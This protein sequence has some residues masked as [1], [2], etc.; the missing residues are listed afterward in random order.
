[1]RAARY[2]GRR[3]IRVEDV[4][5]PEPGPNQCL[6]EIAWSGICGSD[7][8]EYVAGLAHRRAFK[9][10]ANADKPQVR[11]DVRLQNAHTR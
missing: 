7:L 6:V 4:P 1:M 2:Y 3:D 10:C 8:H 5:I 11:S 9:E